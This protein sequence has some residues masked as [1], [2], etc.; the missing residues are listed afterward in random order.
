MSKILTKQ[1][2]SKKIGHEMF[3]TAQLYKA[4]GHR[5]TFKEVR[6]T[7]NALEKAAKDKGEKVQFL[8]KGCNGDRNKTLKG[9]NL[10]LIEEQK[11]DDYYNGLDNEELIEFY[12]LQVTAKRYI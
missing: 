11:W 3:N 8:V 4:K 6:Q 5:F 9:Y 7:I 2:G 10:D 12:Q 1:L